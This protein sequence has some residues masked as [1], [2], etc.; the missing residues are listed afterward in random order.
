MHG[1]SLDKSKENGFLREN[2]DYYRDG[3]GFK[4]EVEEA[5]RR[6]EHKRTVARYHHHPLCT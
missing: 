3:G 6:H 5:C 4:D 1:I 2:R